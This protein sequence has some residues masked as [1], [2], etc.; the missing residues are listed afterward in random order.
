MTCSRRRRLP[1]VIGSKERIE[2]IS[3]PKSS[4]RMGSPTPGGHTSTMPPRF[5]NSPTPLTIIT[6]D[7]LLTTTPTNIPDALQKLPNISGSNARSQGNGA[8]NT[9]CNRAD[10]GAWE[11]AGNSS[12]Q[13]STNYTCTCRSKCSCCNISAS[14]L[15]FVCGRSRNLV[16]RTFMK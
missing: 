14:K 4:I 16:Q 7:Q 10:G 15:V 3:S 11:G 2:S 8:T 9:P 12:C 6:T 1:W 5:A 13:C